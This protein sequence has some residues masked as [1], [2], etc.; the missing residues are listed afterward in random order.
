MASGQGMRRGIQIGE[1]DKAIQ[2]YY[3]ALDELGA[4]GVSHELALRSAF[5][6]LL[7]HYAQQLKW[8][9][10]AE[11]TLTNGSRPDAVLRDRSTLPRGYWEAKDTHDDLETEIRKKIAR[12]YPLTN[13]IFEDTRRGVLFQ[14]R[15][16]VGEFDL[17][18]PRQLVDLLTTFFNHQQ[19][20]YE[21]FE[22]AM[23]AFRE[24]I[25]ELARG[26]GELIERERRENPG[27]RAAFADFFE[28]CKKSVDP[29]IGEAAVEE[30]LT[31]HLLTERLIRTIFDNPDFTRNNVIA[32]EIEKVIAAL[33]ARS[34][35]R[36]EFMR[37]LERFYVPIEQAA[38]FAAFGEDSW[39][40]RQRFLNMV[41]ER[42][43][44]GY[45]VQVADTHGIVY[46]P[47]PIVEF[48]CAS[49]EDVLRTEFG[50]DLSHPDVK[51]LDP[52]T[53]TGNFIVRLMERI[54]PLALPGKY[55]TDLFANEIMLLPYY[56]SSMNIEHA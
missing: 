19:I 52:C 34:F 44:Q 10:I 51:V 15:Q 28:L 17:R 30:M 48:M 3:G 8:T 36:N 45:S 23:A 22:E 43:F 14:N 38:R 42:F 27:F 37:E 12:G 9:L 49:V 54:D 5:Q 35:N 26:M 46:T 55:A 53:G 33:T 20:E 16:R 6:N 21:R 18:V 25:P 32:V 41:Y 50:R 29:H 1:R 24:R 2:A 40:E 47:Q 11:L 31:Q 56:I 7:S 4:Q 13:I 39:S